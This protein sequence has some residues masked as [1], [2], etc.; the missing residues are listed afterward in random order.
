MKLMGGSSTRR[1]P[2]PA[3]PPPRPVI[4]VVVVLKVNKNEALRVERGPF[5]IEGQVLKGWELSRE[6]GYRGLRCCAQ[7]V[8]KFRAGGRD[9]CP[10]GNGAK[11]I[12][13]PNTVR[14]QKL[15]AWDPPAMLLAAQRSAHAAASR[16]WASNK[17][18]RTLS[19][20]I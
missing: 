16:E 10:A 3:L 5:E 4:V 18:T 1:P 9:A 12:A 7:P 13:G 19:I 20:L 6:A 17:A 14:S 15:G 2:P 8:A 11:I